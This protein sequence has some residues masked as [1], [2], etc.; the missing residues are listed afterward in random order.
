MSIAE[1]VIV[2]EI[3]L[4]TSKKGVRL[5]KNIRGMFLTLDGKR[6]VRAGLQAPGA[7]DLVGFKPVIITSEMIGRTFAVLTVFE[8]KTENGRPSPEQKDFVDFV[9]QSGGY[10]GVVRSAEEANK[11]LD[12]CA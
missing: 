12:D 5:F 4:V 11:I 7:S 2:N 9:R 10:A 6:K 8:V 1:T 3:M